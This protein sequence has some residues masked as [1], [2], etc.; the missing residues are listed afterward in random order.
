MQFHTSDGATADHPVQRGPR[1]VARHPRGVGTGTHR[2]A[3]GQHAFDRWRGFGRFRAVTLDE[4]FTL[5]RHAILNRDAA[6]QR[7]DPLDVL[8]GDGF[9]V[10]EKP[11]QA[12]ERNVA[13]NLLEHIEH[14]ADGF[15]VGGVQT[16][17]PALLDQMAHYW[18]QFGFHGLRQVRARFEEV[19]EVRRREHQHFPGAVV[20]QEIIALVQ[21]HA[22]GPVLEVG[23][24]FLRFLGEQVVGDA[25]GQLLVLRQLLDHLVIVRVILET[26]AGIDGTG[27]AQ[28]IEF[29]HELTGRV[30]LILQRQLRPLGQGRVQNHR[31]GPRHQHA[32]R[33][34][35][36][37]THD[38]A[39]RRV[40]RVTGVPGDA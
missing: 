35:I 1:V 13:I 37:V 4:I 30:D 36:G 27:Q 25:H 6:A 15:V 22:A 7:P 34:A 17:R 28:A 20:P 24:L 14:A 5:E 31:I 3:F 39:T 32:G 11:R 40:R 38:L 29:A 19:F 18:F 26:A 9:G 23:Q 2:Y 33:L 21:L 12:V 8:R 16:E 10:V